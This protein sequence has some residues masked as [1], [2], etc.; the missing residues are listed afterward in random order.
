MRSSFASRSAGGKKTKV[1]WNAALEMASRFE[2]GR[3]PFLFDNPTRRFRERAVGIVVGGTAVSFDEQCPAGAE[4]LEC[5][6]E[7]GRDCNQ[8]G[9]GCTVEIRPAEP[10]GALQAAILVEHD[11]G[12]DQAR[13]RA[14]N[15]EAAGGVRDRRQGSSWRLHSRRKMRGIADMAA[16]DLDEM[17]VFARGPHR[18]GMADDPEQRA[19]DPEL[20][21]ERHG[22]GDRAD[23]DGERAWGAAEQQR[24]GQGPV[25][26]DGKAGEMVVNVLGHGDDGA[27]GELEEGEEEGAAAKAIERPKMIWISRRNPPAVSPKAR[28]AR[29]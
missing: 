22:C 26:R 12:R 2:K 19:G 9:L 7:P 3:A 4:A 27:S 17:R 21:A 25:E 15:P 6:I 11:A 29:W 28:S 23:Q 8:L 18:D 16:Q 20:Q 5:V 10:C 24:L 13:P 14:E 1:R